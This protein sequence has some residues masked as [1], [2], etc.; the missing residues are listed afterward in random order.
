MER[1]VSEV[2]G[3]E[4]GARV[5]MWRRRAASA[6]ERWNE[7]VEG[8]EGENVWMG[9][10]VSWGG[11]SD[12]RRGFVNTRTCMRRRCYRL[13]DDSRNRGHT[14]S[15]VPSSHHFPPTTSSPPF[16][17]CLASSMVSASN[18]N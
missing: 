7:R 12:G 6:M 18:F 4:G 1:P 13:Y 2:S 3:C 8:R 17:V 5:R 15:L 11:I 16:S 9:R 10:G 14:S